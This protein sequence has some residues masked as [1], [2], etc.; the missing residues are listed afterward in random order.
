MI[1]GKEII[2]GKNYFWVDSHQKEVKEVVI[3]NGPREEAMVCGLMWDG[4][5]VG[6]EDSR[7]SF[8]EHALFIDIEEAERHLELK[9]LENTLEDIARLRH[10]YFCKFLDKFNEVNGFNLTRNEYGR[11][12]DDIFKGEELPLPRRELFSSFDEAFN[13]MIKENRLYNHNSNKKVLVDLDALIYALYNKELEKNIQE[14]ANFLNPKEPVDEIVKAK[15]Q[16]WIEAFQYLLDKL[17]LDRNNFGQENYTP[18]LVK[19]AFS[20]A[21]EKK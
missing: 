1:K 19:H 14:Y 6:K 21:E 10:K 13:L 16:G 20:I 8:N 5:V 12:I 4:S 15:Q 18:F 11:L 2:V 17:S 7:Q 9:I 3:D